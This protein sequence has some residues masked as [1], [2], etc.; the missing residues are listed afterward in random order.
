MCPPINIL[1]IAMDCIVCYVFSLRVI[2]QMG[3][4][5]QHQ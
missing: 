2:K 1:Y 5:K 4:H 3:V